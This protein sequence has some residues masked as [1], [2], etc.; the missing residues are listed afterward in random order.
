MKAISIRQPW[1]WLVVNGH[2]D[3]ENRSWATKFR[4]KVL[5][6]TGV[7]RVTKAEYEEFQKRC[8]AARIRDYPAIDE[9]KRGGIVGSVEIVDC[10]E[11]S[12]SKWFFR[13]HGFVLTN[14]QVE[15]FKPLMGKLGIWEVKKLRT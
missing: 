9:L 5:V 1:A 8:R 7:H 12:K 6:H 2:K 4:G 10:L 11:K 14:A 15:R 13:P 3:I